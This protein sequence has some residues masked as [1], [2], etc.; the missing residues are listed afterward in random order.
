MTEVQQAL[1]LA[2]FNELLAELS[3]RHYKIVVAYQEPG[4]SGETLREDY[5]SVG[6]SWAEALGLLKW[7]QMRFEQ[8]ASSLFKNRPEYDTDE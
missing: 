2:T 3:K 5:C 6:C 1:E 8:D 4:H 7:A